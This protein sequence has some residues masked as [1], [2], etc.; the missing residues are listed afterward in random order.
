MTE[1]YNKLSKENERLKETIK[2]LN[3]EIMEKNYQIQKLE[4][5]LMEKNA[6]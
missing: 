5:R 6:W 3:S 1:D 2:V 4:S